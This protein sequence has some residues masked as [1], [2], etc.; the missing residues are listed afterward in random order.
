MLRTSLTGVGVAGGGTIAQRALSA[1][2]RLGGSVRFVPDNYAG[3]FID[4]TGLTPITAVGDVIGRVNDRGVGTQNATQPTTVN[5]PLVG[6]NAQ[7]RKTMVFDGSNDGLSTTSQ[8][9]AAGWCCAGFNAGTVAGLHHLFG[10]G[11][12]SAT[13]VGVWLRLPNTNNSASFFASNGTLREFVSTPALAVFTGLPRVFECGWDVS[14]MF[15]GVDGSLTSA[16]KT[17]NPT[18]TKGLWIGGNPS[19]GGFAGG[20]FSA[21]VSTPVLPSTSDRALIRRW[22]G[23]LQGQQL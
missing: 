7:G 23:S 13:D 2:R 1:I 20:S 6:Q 19:L 4:S 9:G 18:T 10:N 17:V 11:S 15:V 8:T 14:S 5:K 22:I 3:T 12:S 16:A 21:F